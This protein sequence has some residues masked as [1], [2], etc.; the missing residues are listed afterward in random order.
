MNNEILC[1]FIPVSTSPSPS[2][3]PSTSTSTSTSTSNNNQKQKKEKD[4]NQPYKKGGNRKQC[5]RKKNKRNRLKKARFR[6]FADFIIDTFGKKQLQ[7]GILDV[8]GGKASLALEWTLERNIACTVVDPQNG[9][10]SAFTTRRIWNLSSKEEEGET[11][12]EDITAVVSL[13]WH[14][15]TDKHS[16]NMSLSNL[17]DIQ[18]CQK[19]NT[20][21]IHK[22][23][24]YLHKK[25]LI[26]HKC[27]FNKEYI[28]NNDFWDH[29]SIVLGMHPDEATE[30]IVDFAIQYNK[31][32]AVVPCCVFP[33]LFPNRKLKDG[34][35]VRTLDQFITYLKAKHP[36]IQST[37]LM[38]MPGCNVVIYKC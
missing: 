37:T 29:S 8:A 13:S 26:F 2:P 38:D 31:P 33:S 3:S 34:Q 20:E 17:F 9:R 5:I 24:S 28:Q 4:S 32:F 25:G 27:Y 12:E 14:S 22:M 16:N 35:L 1:Q 11:K 7:N 30:D 18:E 10:F 21:T 15:K 6:I 36:D 23:E 19:F